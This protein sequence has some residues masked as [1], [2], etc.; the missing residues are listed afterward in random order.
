MSERVFRFQSLADLEG[1]IVEVEC[2]DILVDF[3][4]DVEA[5]TLTFYD[6]LDTDMEETIGESGGVE[7]TDASR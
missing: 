6:D 2:A 5:V 3:E 1:C 4:E 7:L